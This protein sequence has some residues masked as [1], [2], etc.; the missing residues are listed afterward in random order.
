[1]ETFDRN[2]RATLFKAEGLSGELCFTKDHLAAVNS[3]EAWKE[4]AVQAM[5][6]INLQE[7][8][9]ELSLPL[10]VSISENILP[11]IRKLKAD[12]AALKKYNAKLLDEN[13][14]LSNENAALRGRLRVVEECYKKFAHL[15]AVFSGKELGEGFMC[16]FWQTIK[17]AIE[18]GE[19]G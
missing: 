12:N 19:K 16:T 8:G 5:N 4:A 7:V 6:G 14:D 1:M 9:R 2:E 17:Q 10:G 3:L 15:D 13:I 11:R 18:K